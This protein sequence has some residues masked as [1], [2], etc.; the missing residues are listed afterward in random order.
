MEVCI[1]AK[2]ATK[3]NDTAVVEHVEESSPPSDSIRVRMVMTEVSFDL[4]KEELNHLLDKFQEE[5][6][7]HGQPKLSLPK[8]EEAA[9]PETAVA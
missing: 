7:S 2:K 4:P 1:M 3:D 9:I 5:F 6:T 8:P